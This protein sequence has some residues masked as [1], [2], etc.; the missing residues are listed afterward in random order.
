[1]PVCAA[2]RAVLALLVVRRLR[3]NT[4]GHAHANPKK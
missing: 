3:D 2:Y 1:L 4:G